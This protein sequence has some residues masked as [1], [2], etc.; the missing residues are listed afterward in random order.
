VQNSKCNP[1]IAAQAVPIPF[2]VT[3]EPVALLLLGLAP[4][5][6]WVLALVLPVGERFLLTAWRSLLDSRFGKTWWQALAAALPPLIP[7]SAYLQK[8]ST[9]TARGV[10]LAVLLLA[11]ALVQLYGRASE[12][13]EKTNTENRFLDLVDEIREGRSEAAEGRSEA[14]EGRR[15]QAA[16]LAEQATLLL[17]LVDEIRE[18]RSEVEAGLAEQRTRLLAILTAIREGTE[19][20]EDL[21][22]VLA[23]GIE[24]LTERVRANK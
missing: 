23:Q 11:I 13:R 15:E 4:L 18:G 9:E 14:A 19:G 24:M 1:G 16:R 12:Q 7:V 3:R 22:R 21:L 17:D 5:S 20:Q 2:L 6:P 10:T 8:N